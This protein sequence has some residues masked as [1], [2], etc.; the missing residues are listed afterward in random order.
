MIHFFD[1]NKPTKKDLSKNLIRTVFLLAFSFLNLSTKAHSAT[2]GLSSTPK[3][4]SS[5]DAG[6]LNKQIESQLPSTKRIIIPRPSSPLVDIPTTPTTPSQ[7]ETVRFTLKEIIFKNAKLLD[8]V[9][10]QNACSEFLNQELDI[11]DLESI[12]AK[13]IAAY[14]K[15]GYVVETILPEQD[16]T[17]GTLIIDIIEAKVGKFF[18]VPDADL[19]ISDS[20]F[21]RIQGAIAQNNPPDSPLD[22]NDFE[23]IALLISDLN[24]IIP[25]PSI[26]AGDEIGT[27]D[28]ILRLS[29][30]PLFRGI[31]LVDNTG[32]SNTG[33]SRLSTQLSWSSPF[34]RGELIALSTSKNENSTFFRLGY[35]TP[36]TIGNSWSGTIWDINATHMQYEILSKAVDLGTLEPPSGQSKSFSTEVSQPLYRSLSANLSV[37]AGYL[38]REA[39]D[40]DRNIYDTDTKI[41]TGEVYTLGINGNYFDSFL[42]G[43]VN[44]FSLKVNR[45]VSKYIGNQST[46]ET[47]NQDGAAGRFWKTVFSVARQQ[48]FKNSWSLTS[49]LQAQQANKNLESSEKFTLGG[50][51]S[52]RAF[53]GSE[54]AGS[55]GFT[56]KNELTKIINDDLQISV[57]YDWGWVHKYIIRR[58]PQ[59][60][61]LPLYDNELNT[62]SMSGYGFNINYN[63]INDLNINLTLARRAKP[64]P[65][66]IQNNPEK[67][68]LDSDGTLKMNRLWLT[69]NYK[70]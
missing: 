34:H 47:S 66:A 41:T 31:A 48:S 29:K 56:I 59:G 19:E 49:T 52:I 55:R 35:T 68:G 61:K 14:R 40:K 65:F 45:G 53:P 18:I 67:N 11:E 9:S 13:V 43:G 63:P 60:Q 33:L 42:M 4:T 15:Q 57:F 6:T 44:Q 20:L 58:G 26:K 1:W 7:D 25:I 2:T 46:I 28:L 51:N 22:L 3:T 70:F 24:G 30:K 12:K 62:G 21:Q 36:I 69:L 23:R 64:N 37:S 54:G 39:A 8:T 17:D 27:T 5:T 50:A 16:L 32:S 38:Q 10:L